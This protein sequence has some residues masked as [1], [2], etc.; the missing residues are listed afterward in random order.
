MGL[1]AVLAALQRPRTQRPLVICLGVFGLVML[2]S[3][4]WSHRPWWPGAGFDAHADRLHSL[5]AQVAG[6][7][8][9]AAVGLRMAQR[10][11]LRQGLD[12]L[13]IGTALA[14]LLAPLAML[15]RAPGPGAAQR[16]MFGLTYLWLVRQ[17]GRSATDGVREIAKA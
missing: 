17:A 8:F 1:G 9:L 15:L 4:V 2:A 13:D 3:A 16:V 6:G 14:A 12:V 11:V 5:A 10:W 7:A